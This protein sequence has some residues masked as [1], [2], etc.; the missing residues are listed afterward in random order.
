MENML[1]L[2][3]E[4][5]NIDISYI[6]PAGFNPN[7]LS[8]K[9]DF[10]RQSILRD[11]ENSIGSH[12][13]KLSL[14]I[15]EY[16]R[17]KNNT[18]SSIIRKNGVIKDHIGHQD[19]RTADIVDSV[20]YK[21]SQY[22][23][24]TIF[25]EFQG[26]F[27]HIQSVVCAT[28]QNIINTM[29]QNFDR[30]YLNELRSITE[31]YEEIYDDI[32][33]ISASKDRC[34]SYLTHAIGNRQK[35]LKLINHFLEKLWAWPNRLLIRD[36]NN[37]NYTSVN[38]NELSNDYLLCRQAISNYVVCLVFEHVLS[39]NIDDSSKDKVIKKIDRNLNKFKEVDLAI[40]NSLQQRDS[41]NWQ[42]YQ[43]YTPYENN[44]KGNDRAGINWFVQQCEQDAGFEVREVE[45]I[46]DKSKLLLENIIIE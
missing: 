27:S 2:L 9:S 45:R 46:F 20:F 35:T 5:L 7:Q 34:N 32:G 19:L 12:V 38:Y 15:E 10:L 43:W 33:D 25:Q 6:Q 14:P 17:Y 42:N 26:F 18:V 21:V 39:G 36:F 44:L 1:T 22:Y 13:L 29:H 37:R 16:S 28:Q 41:D 31:F 24:Q 11:T 23:T 4:Q 3:N 8:V 30:E 40:K